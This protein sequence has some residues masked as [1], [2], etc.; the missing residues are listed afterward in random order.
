MAKAAAEL[1]VTQP[2]VSKMVADM[3]HTLGVRLLDRKPQGVEPTLYGQVLLK[4]GDAVDRK[5]V[6]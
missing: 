2:A 5:S 6:V 4:W 1:A 3:E